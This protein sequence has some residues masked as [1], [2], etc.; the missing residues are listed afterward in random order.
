L[1]EASAA[2][3]GPRIG[4]DPD[5]GDALNALLDLELEGVAPALAP[6]GRFNTPVTLRAVDDVAALRALAEGPAH[7]ALCAAATRDAVLLLRPERW[8]T[9][10]DRIELRRVLCH[11]LAHVLLFQ[12]CAPAG[13]DRPVAISTWFREGM[14][15]V[16]SEGRPDARRRQRAAGHPDGA[17]LALADAATLGDHPEAAYDLAATL[18]AAWYE[19]AGARGLGALCRAMRAGASF[20]QAH[21]QAVGQAEAAWLAGALAELA[22][23]AGAGSGLRGRP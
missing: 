20:E 21:Q 15:V 22:R 23:W 13:R 19:A 12:R 8:P 9:P 11:E 4:L 2:A 18:F 3:G 10:P 17:A 5:N 1:T 14:A 7:G 6:W 16:A